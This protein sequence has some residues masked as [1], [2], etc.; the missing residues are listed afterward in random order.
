MPQHRSVKYLGGFCEYA[1]RIFEHGQETIMRTGIAIG[2]V[3]VTILILAVSRIFNPYL[4]VLPLL[5]ILS[6]VGMYRAFTSS[7]RK[8]KREA[9]SLEKTFITVLLR[10]A[11]VIDS[12]VWTRTA[13]AFKALAIILAAAGEKVVL[14]DCQ[15]QE[16]SNAA[17]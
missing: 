10:D 7:A 14:Y 13:G 11:V 9:R 6:L 4:M 5:P 12:A 15:Y 8:T 2:F 17:S 16:L 1:F 3:L